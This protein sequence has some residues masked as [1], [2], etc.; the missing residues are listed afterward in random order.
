MIKKICRRKLETREITMVG[1]LFAV[2]IVL[3]ATGLGFLPV[4]PFKTTIM[5]IPVIIGGIVGGPIVGAFTGLLFGI[6]SIIQAI[7]TPSPVSFIFMNPV[8]A[9]IPRILI[10]IVSYYVYKLFKRKS[11]KF[12][13]VIGIVAGSFTNTIGVLA[14]VYILYINAYANA[15]H[16]SYSTAVK[17]LLALV[18]NGFLSAAMA[19]VI[20]VPIIMV[21][22]K[23]RK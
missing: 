23:I 18:A 13:I 9:V 15:L 2:T 21:V 3:G 5:H 22:K 7:N 20:S 6:F 11:E 4:P 16:I 17:T 19:L 8:V 12:G 14:M 10:G 1:L